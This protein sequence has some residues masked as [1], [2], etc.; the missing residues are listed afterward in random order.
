[1]SMQ[2]THTS[3]V[4]GRFT[5][6]A[7]ERHIR[8]KHPGCPEFAVIYIAELIASRDWEGMS[9]GGAVGTTMQGIMRHTMTE[10]DALLLAGI[11]RLEA[12]KRVQPKVNALLATW[13][14]PRGKNPV[15]P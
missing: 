8:K 15:G 13:A 4:T 11:D 2:Q 10:Y 5:K 6:E 3:N 9:L 7:V 1:M 14:K 12:R